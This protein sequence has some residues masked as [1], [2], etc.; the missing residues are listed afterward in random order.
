MTET[1]TNVVESNELARVEQP[2]DTISLIATA[3]SH[4]I[5]PSE[6][7][8]LY[9]LHE[10]DVKNKAAE[11]FS[12]AITG[13]QSECHTV[14]KEREA[15]VKTKGGGEFSYKFASFDDI[16]REAAPILAKYKIAISFNTSPVDKF[17]KITCRV[18][19]GIHFEDHDFTMPIPEAVVN[20]SQRYGMALSYAKRYCFCAALNIVVTDK[21][22]DA[23]TCL[24]TLIATETEEIKD[25]IRDKKV[26]LTRF[27]EWAE[28]ENV[29]DILRSNF[30]KTVDMLKRRQVRE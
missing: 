24:D 8:E 2:Q 20:D 21:D 30:A 19:H 15:K 7:T 13:F 23:A 6:M 28:V 1:A 25:L 4:G 22:D 26:N 17:I 10:R 18:R 11:A 9:A 5:K 3:L 12:L 16:M 29:E 14:F 27:L